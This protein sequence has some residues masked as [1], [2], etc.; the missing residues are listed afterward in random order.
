MN[1]K[2]LIK[3]E[4][5]RG[6]INLMKRRTTTAQINEALTNR[7]LSVTRVE[8]YHKTS[9]ITDLIKVESFIEDFQFLCESGIFMNCIGWY[10]EKI[11]KTNQYIIECCRLD[12][13]AENIVTVHLRTNDGMSNDDVKNTLLM[14][15]ED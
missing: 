14:K 7:L 6:N 15:E 5:N 12:G 1:N 11:Y 10:F 13:S 4:T 9:R 3:K 2:Y 8:C